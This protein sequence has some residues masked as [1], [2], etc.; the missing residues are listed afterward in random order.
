M[1]SSAYSNTRWR[2]NP[3]PLIL[4]VLCGVLFVWAASV[5]AQI[6]AGGE[7]LLEAGNGEAPEQESGTFGAAPFSPSPKTVTVDL[8]TG[9]GQIST[10][11]PS[12]NVS[13]EATANDTASG[14]VGRASGQWHDDLTVDFTATSLNDA[15]LTGLSIFLFVNWDIAGFGN[16]VAGYGFSLALSNSIGSAGRTS[17]YNTRDGFTVNEFGFSSGNSGSA[18]AGEGTIGRW[19]LADVVKLVRIITAASSAWISASPAIPL[20]TNPLTARHAR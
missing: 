19:P 20:P 17:G 11:G 5:P 7:F 13:S 18:L 16:N 10:T 1:N 14:I 6:Q 9:S 2:T 15:Q 4:P 8:G 3:L 12:L